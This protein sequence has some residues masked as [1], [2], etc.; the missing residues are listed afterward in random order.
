[1]EWATLGTD[2]PFAIQKAVGEWDKYRVVDNTAIGASGVKR[3][4]STRGAWRKFA[5]LVEGRKV[6]ERSGLIT[7]VGD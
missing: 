2:G 7:T 5:E 6:L 1:M 3:Y 4:S